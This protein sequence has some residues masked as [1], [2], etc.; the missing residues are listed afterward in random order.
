MDSR[1]QTTGT[2]KRIQTTGADNMDRQK[3]QAIEYRQP[4]QPRGYRQHGRQH[5]QT[6]EYNQQI[7]DNIGYIQK[8]TGI[9][10]RQ[11][12]IQTTGYRQPE[13]ENMDR[14]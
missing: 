1:I 9:G 2:Y 4:G 10:N 8:E 3:G 5:G 13:T 14:Q 7:I 11:H 6:R 12:E